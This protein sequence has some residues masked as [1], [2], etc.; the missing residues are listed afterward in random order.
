MSIL[1]GLSG[2]ERVKLVIVAIITGG[3]CFLGLVGGMVALAL[4][5]KDVT[6]V[7]AALGAV[8]V[9]VIPAL[10]TLIYAKASQ[11][12]SNTNGSANKQMDFQ[13]IQQTQLL[14]ALRES[15]AALSTVASLNTKQR[16]V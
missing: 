15:H 5:D 12:V 10:G 4:F 14:D 3:L 7:F 13:Q 2:A 16:D 1:A 8:I 9:I 11:A 6:S